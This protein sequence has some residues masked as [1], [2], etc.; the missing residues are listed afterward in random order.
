LEPLRLISLIM[1][2]DFSI[3]NLFFLLFLSITCLP[4]FF[5]KTFINQINYIIRKFWWAGIQEENNTN[6]I[7]FI[8]G[9]ISAIREVL[10]LRTWVSLTKVLSIILLRTLLL[11]KTIF[12]Q[13]FLRLNITQDNN[14]WTAPDSTFRSVYWSSILPVKNH[15]HSNARLHLHNANSSIRASS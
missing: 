12:F 1:L 11:I 2:V 6:H 10:V 4:F 5:S 14:F 9:K 13:L 15:L 3:L 7:T 8:S